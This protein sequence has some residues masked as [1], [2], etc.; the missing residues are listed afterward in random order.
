MG[1][2]RGFRMDMIAQRANESEVY[3]NFINSVDSEKTRLEYAKT[4]K[5]FLQ[6]VG[7]AD[8]EQLLLSEE[9]DKQRLE[10]KIKNYIIY[11]RQIK[12]LAPYTVSNYIT[13]LVHFFDMNDVS[14]NWKKPKKFKAKQRGVIEDRPYTKEQIK[15]LIGRAALR[16]K[17]IILVM[18][19]TS[20]YVIY[21]K[22]KNIIYIEL[23]YIK[24]SRKHI[25]HFAHQ[26]VP[27]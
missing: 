26:N 14:I 5:Y 21:K 22:L 13:P 2:A 7:V 4:L 18:A 19:S 10:S 16:D 9:M 8:Y 27:D 24:M 15:I 20:D 6:F 12:K 23:M 25:Q 3:S 17:C 11:L 1:K